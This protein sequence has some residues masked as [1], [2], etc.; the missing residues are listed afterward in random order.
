MCCGI[1]LFPADGLESSA[2][3]GGGGGGGGAE[4]LNDLLDVDVPSPSDGQ[5]LVYVNSS[6]MWE[7][8][9]FVLPDINLNDLLDVNLTSPS[10]GEFLQYDSG[11]GK[12]IN[13]P[14]T[15]TGLG[16]TGV[17]PRVAFWGGTTTLSSDPHFLWDQTNNFLSIGTSP[18][19]ADPA[20]GIGFNNNSAISWKQFGT[21][22]GGDPTLRADSG[23][24]WVFSLTNL[25]SLYV[26]MIVASAADATWRFGAS[27]SHKGHV[28]TNG[29]FEAWE[30]AIGTGAVAADASFKLRNNKKV[31]WRNF[32]NTGD[33]ALWVDTANRWVMDVSD[34]ATDVVEIAANNGDATSFR[35]QTNV[36]TTAALASVEVDGF[37]A[38]HLDKWFLPAGYM[39]ASGCYRAPNNVDIVVARNNT[40]SADVPVLKVT[41]ANRVKIANAAD[42]PSANA[43]GVLKNDGAGDLSWEGV[44]LDDLTDVSITSPVLTNL[45]RFNGTNWVNVAPSVVAGD[46]NLDDL[47]DVSAAGPSDHDLVAWNSGTSMWSKTTITDLAD[48]LSINHIG[49]VTITGATN[50]QVLT[51]NGSAWVN[52]ALPA[53]VASAESG[54][55]VVRGVVVNGVK[56][57]GSGF[58][59]S[60]GAVAFDT[61]F[62]SRPSVV[63]TVFDVDCTTGT[64]KGMLAPEVDPTTTGFSVTG[65]AICDVA[66]AL[67]VTTVTNISYSFIAIGPA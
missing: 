60:L 24:R 11:T 61:A 5:Y 34:S 63:V 53:S 58:T 19:T 9:D 25:A 64:Y 21:A 67:N 28:A 46:I 42:W 57:A 29:S 13:T 59:M 16:G 38:A 12:W 22:A 41:T 10:N 3:G 44:G 26:D 48:L 54:L 30:G 52:S 55:K 39:A 7:A 15:P 2:G 37:F 56:N 66:G 31:G 33:L 51:Y 4:Y 47:A 6:S 43:A 27:S 65:N 50:G 23:N 20:G 8:V 17:A 45:L 62:S 32:D 36:T 1:K 40:H 14:A 35:F 49:D 18:A